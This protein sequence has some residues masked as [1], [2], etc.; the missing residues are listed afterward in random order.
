[1]HAQSSQGS[2]HRLPPRWLQRCF[3]LW[4][5]NYLLI[6]SW[7]DPLISLLNSPKN[8]FFLA[9]T[10][11]PVSSLGNLQLPFLSKSEWKGK[12]WWYA[13]LHTHSPTCVISFQL[14]KVSLATIYITA[15]TPPIQQVPDTS[16]EQD[17]SSIDFTTLCP[18]S[19]S[20]HGQK[21]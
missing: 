11:Y 14:E 12:L 10:A 18:K 3:G 7:K 2:S 9:L 20:P 15:W 13:C 4:S 17:S 6:P 16:K 5:L 19:I 8:E 1:M 21:W